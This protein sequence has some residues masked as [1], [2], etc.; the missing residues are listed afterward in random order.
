MEKAIQI[1]VDANN[2]QYAEAYNLEEETKAE[3]IYILEPVKAP[4]KDKHK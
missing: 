1:R 4:G 3:N 2:K